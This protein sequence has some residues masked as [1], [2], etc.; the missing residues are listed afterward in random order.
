MRSLLF[1]S[2][3]FHST[4]LQAAEPTDITVQEQVVVQRSILPGS[5]T[6]MIAVGHP[7]G[8]NYAFNA[9]HCAPEYA[10]F[11]EFLDFRGETTGRG[12]HRSQIL[13]LPFPLLHSHKKSLPPLRIGAPQNLPQKIQFLGYLRNSKTGEPTFQYQVDELL[14]EQ[15]VTSPEK[16]RVLIQLHFPLP[17]SS[18][19]WYHLEKNLHQKVSLGKGLTW[20]NSKII[21]IPEHQTEAQIEI[22]LKPKKKAFVRKTPQLTGEEL[23]TRYCQSCHSTDG[24]QLIGPTFK[25]LWGRKQQITRQGKALSIH[26]DTDYIYESI[27]KPQAAIVKGYEHIPMA[28]FSEALSEKDIDRLIEYLRKLGK[29]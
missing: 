21:Q 4:F 9:V 17:L 7:N 6:R 23:Y 29:G 28:N 27:V 20:T 13:G 3:L 10:W 1:F 5:S 8:F 12:G 26:I 18:P 15:R 16:H 11:G 2:L 14:V 19:V 24:T 25:N 22:L